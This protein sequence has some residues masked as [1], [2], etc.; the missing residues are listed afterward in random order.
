VSD[1]SQTD[2][3]YFL[4]HI[5]KTAG[6]TIQQHLAEHCAPGVFWQSQGKLRPGR[7]APEHLPDVRRARVIAGHHLSR[8][9]E[10]L[11]PGRAIRRIVLLRDPTQ[12][13][14]SLYN[15]QMMDNISK[16]IPTY[17]FALH[18]Q[19][20]PHNFISHFLLSRWLEIPWSRLMAMSDEQKY[21]LLNRTLAGFWFVGAHTDCERV[22]AVIGSRLGVPP[23]AVPRNSSNEL[24]GRTGWRLVS[25]E[26]LSP[27]LRATMLA[28]H[29]LDHALWREWRHAGFDTAA[30]RPRPLGSTGKAGFLR[31]E[32][33]R[34]WYLLRRF[35]VV[36]WP[37][38]RRAGEASGVIIEQADRARDAGQW[39]DAANGYG[40]A[41]R[42][43]PD[44]W[45]IWV[46]YGHALKESGR[47][48][49]AETAYR[50]SLSL[51]ADSADA[52]LQLGHALKL[53]GRRDEAQEAYLRSAALDPEHPAARGELLGLG[54][55]AEQ[56][57]QAIAETQAGPSHWRSEAIG[58]ADCSRQ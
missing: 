3:V 14:L 51:N 40:E 49:E 10:A 48:T 54:W 33:V 35:E 55:P 29:R 44:A 34:P 46:Q 30:I 43:V 13:Q 36:G 26:A 28:Q 45:A 41:V 23:I 16:G 15:W 37:D 47:I 53:Q 6:Q 20:L 9:H 39:E 1:P 21:R 24:Q 22:I 7:R 5:P 42:T 52:H 56:V 17:S 58:P 19:T 18:L 2:P 32:I 11:F 27:R 38:L 57:K 4:L 8:S 25:A 31:H 50:Q 12:L